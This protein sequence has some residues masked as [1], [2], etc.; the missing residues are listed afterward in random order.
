MKLRHPALVLG[1][2]AAGIVAMAALGALLLP[3][4]VDSQF[5]RNR[6]RAQ[7]GKQFAGHL[8]IRKIQFFWWPRPNVVVNDAQLSFDESHRASVE[9]LKIYPSITGLLTARFIVRRALLEGFRVNVYVPENSKPIDLEEL[10]KQISA[11]LLLLTKGL[12]GAMVDLSNGSAEIKVG[13]KPTVFLDEIRARTVVSPAALRFQL[14]GRSGLWRSLKIEGNVSQETL[15]T[16]LDIV[17][18]RLKLKDSLAFFSTQ[19]VE[20]TRSA[21]ATLEL[22]IASVGL[23]RLEANIT[24]SAGP[25]SV[26]RRGGNTT[27]DIK[28]FNGAITYQDNLFQAD[29]EQLVLGTPQLRASGQLKIAPDSLSANVKVLDLDIAKIKALTPETKADDLDKVLRY[30][31]AGRIPEITVQS[32]GRSLTEMASSKNMILSATLRDGQLTLPEPQLEF[33]NVAGSVR[34]VDGVLEAQG[35]AAN[36]G[37]AKA[38]N[39]TLKIGLERKPTPFH[40]DIMVRTGAPELHAALLKLVHDP[41][42]RGELLKLRHVEGELSGRLILGETIDAMAPVVAISEAKVSADYQPVPFPIVIRRGQLKYDRAVIQLANADGSVGHSTFDDLDL[43]WRQDGSRELSV[44]LKRT[45]LD[46]Q[47]ADTLLRKLGDLK[48]QLEKIKSIHGEL[49]LQNLSLKGAYDDPA[50]WTFA[51]TGAWK[52]VDIQH[53]DFPG[54]IRLSRGRFEANEHRVVFADAL[55]AISDASFHGGGT[56]QYERA[57]L[58]QIDASGGGTVGARMT[59]W[60]GRYANF[61]EE[62]N[63]RSPLNIASAHLAWDAGGNLSLR[64][65]A[66][67]AN[68]PRLSFDAVKQPQGFQIPLFRV[69]DGG[70]RAR[71]AVRFAKDTVDLSFSGELTQRMLDRIFTSSPLKGGSLRGDIQV[72]ATLADRIRF[73]GRGEISG[74]N[75]PIPMG[76]E[77]ALIEKISV[78]AYPDSLWIRS[79]EL[80]WLKSRLAVSGKII[81]ENEA[82]LLDLD[83]KGDRLDW[84]ELQKSFANKVREP[85]QNRTN[86]KSF[87]DIE[88]TIRLKTDSFVFEQFDLSPLEATVNF[89]PSLIRADIDRGD[90][91]GITAK[92]RVDIV[93]AEIGVDLQLSAKDALLEPTTDCLTNRNDIT[94]RFSLTARLAGR[95]NGRGV[96]RALKGNFEFNARD[97]EFIRSPGIDATFDYLNGTGDFKLPFP[98]LDR[99]TFPYRSIGVKGRIEGEL[100]ICDEVTVDS[101]VLDLSGQGKVDL[102]RKQ[103][104]GKGLITV[105]KPVDEVIR[106][107]PLINSLLGGTVLAIPVRITGSLDRPDVSYLSPADVGAELLNIP[108]R[109]LGMPLGALRLFIPSKGTENNGTK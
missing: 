40:L 98:D 64:G 103:V 92:G 45:M 95:G 9:S 96:L 8:T 65:Q 69:D 35:L 78:E 73:S 41:A 34:L 89:S 1:T 105:L 55:A 39:G 16:K 86:T 10:K 101:S 76:S 61:P 3:R 14:S 102:A 87:P 63:L 51:S 28:R 25:I 109:I 49:E 26:A 91:C 31:P 21:E 2:V 67:V 84:Q 17:V 50:R 32:S 5:I 12:P 75:L 90:A 97:G 47:Q 108:L 74:D 53:A 77:R 27:V 29:V 48:P 106:R 79:A 4:M 58:T 38:W 13:D 71:F 99:E 20:S 93:N 57:A 11:G 94:G 56:L 6:I 62:L 22:K 82:V 104:D 107:L 52:Q 83:V 18:Q 23:R 80:R 85:E 24:G 60:L 15:A 7:L 59:Q 37:T 54:R 19:F 33:R 72:T 88:G 68:G 70:Q 100:I 44:E 43:A 30:L 46:L 81:P 36:L 42:V 66:T